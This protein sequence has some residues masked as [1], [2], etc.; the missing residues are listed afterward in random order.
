MAVPGWP[1]AFRGTDAIRA[2][3][4]TPGQLRGPNY[5]RLFPDTYVRR[6]DEPPDLVV[7]SLAAYLYTGRRGILSGYSAAEVQQASCGPLDAP[8]ELT[9]PGGGHPRPGLLVHRDRLDRDEIQMCRGLPVTT[10]SHGLRPGPLAGTA[11][12]GRGRGGCA[13][14]SQ[15]GR[16]RSRRRRVR[17]RGRAAAGEAV[18]GST[19]ERPAAAGRRAGRPAVRVAHGDAAAAGAGAP[20]SPRSRG[21]VPGAGRSAPPRRVAIPST[22]SAS[23]TRAP[24]TQTPTGCC[25]TWAA[26]P[27]S[28]PTRG[29]STASPSSRS[30]ASKT[31]SRRRSDGRWA[32]E[33]RE[34]AASVVGTRSNNAP[35]HLA[36]RG[37]A[38]VSATLRGSVVSARRSR[39]GSCRPSPRRLPGRPAW[40]GRCRPSRTRSPRRAPSS[41]PPGR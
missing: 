37:Q 22:A 19:R 28:W 26:T 40:P 17:P 31:G 36:R 8:A 4:V 9:L 35:C 23:S 15:P 6:G 12:R 38:R 18:S 2:G 29:A 34:M 24:T 11:R 14:E 13:G 1:V 16:P 10:R 7:R 5:L 25:A 21:A 41:C 20:R 32:A 39:W 33:R 30:T 27:A 3:L